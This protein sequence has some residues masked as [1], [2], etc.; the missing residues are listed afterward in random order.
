MA[1][2][3]LVGL[4]S[5]LSLA[6][7]SSSQDPDLK[8]GSAYDELRTSGFPVGLLPTN[9]LTYSLNR[10]S[11]AF[12][13]DLDDRCRVTLPPDNYLATYSRRVTGKLA[14]RRISDLDGIRV[15]AF[16]RWWSITGIRSTGDDLVFEVG[17]VS[18]KYP[19]RNFDES[20]DC[21]GRSPRKA[22]S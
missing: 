8:S 22:A 16:F 10:T 3:V 20:P 2:A 17:V 18:A 5:F 4:V 14:D 11:G 21:E 13:V 15:K 19:S 7:L 12:T 1:K 6:L 9:V